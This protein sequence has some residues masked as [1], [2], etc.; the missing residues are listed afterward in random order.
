MAQT[1]EWE[2]IKQPVEAPVA[3]E[4]PVPA[5]L[6]S[7]A[8]CI[9]TAAEVTCGEIT[10][11]RTAGGFQQKRCNS[12]ISEVFTAS[13]GSCSNSLSY[14]LELLM[15]YSPVQESRRFSFLVGIL[16]SSLPRRGV[17]IKMHTH[18]YKKSAK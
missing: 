5:K 4:E 10:S 1:R 8:G 12:A 17:R 2:T 15:K 11:L 18:A 6:A 13:I 14:L 7:L 3:A 16:T 9:F